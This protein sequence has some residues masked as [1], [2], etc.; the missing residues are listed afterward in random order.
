MFGSTWT[1]I[2]KPSRIVIPVEYE[3]TGW[4]IAAPSSLNSMM[5]PVLS[6]SS[7]SSSPTIAALRRMFWRPV[8]SWWNPEPSSRIEATRP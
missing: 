5:S 3:R 6:R 4:S 1:A 2:E 7:R 8:N